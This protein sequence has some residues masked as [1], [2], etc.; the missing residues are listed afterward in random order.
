[1]DELKERQSSEG[2][3]PQAT[4]IFRS[5]RSIFRDWTEL[6]LMKIS[7]VSLFSILLACGAVAASAQVVP[8]ATA[9]QFSVTAGGMGSISQPD[10]SQIYGLGTSP[11]RTYGLGAYVDLHFTRWIQIEGEGRWQ[12]FNTVTGGYPEYNGEDT[13]LIGPRLPVHTFRF[14][15]ATPYGKFLV[16][17]GDAKFLAGPTFAMAF[18][19]GVDFRVSKRFSVR[20]PDFEYQRWNIVDQNVPTALYPYVGSVGVSYKIF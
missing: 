13:Y 7:I 8:S 9:R 20:L 17:I 15:H 19:G 12:R 10:F 1:L 14:L 6:V 18:G 3:S 4:S 11:N 5:Y 16:G 2:L